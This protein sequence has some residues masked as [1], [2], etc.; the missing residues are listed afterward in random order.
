VSERVAFEAT[1]FS[2]SVAGIRPAADAN[3]SVNLELRAGYVID[4]SGRDDRAE[5]RA[6]GRPVARLPRNE[7][8]A[9]YLPAL[10]HHN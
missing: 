3:V 6:R 8:G 2:L 9:D 7:R 4:L 10:F 5:H 1:R